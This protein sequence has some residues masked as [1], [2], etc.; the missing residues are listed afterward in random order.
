MSPGILVVNGT[1]TFAAGQTYIAEISAA[2]TPSPY[3]PIYNDAVWATG[4][5]SL[6]DINTPTAIQIQRYPALPSPDPSFGQ[7]FTILRAKYNTIP[8]PNY[9]DNFPDNY[10]TVSTTD[11]AGRYLLVT[12]ANTGTNDGFPHTSNEYAVYFVRGAAGYVFP[13]VSPTVTQWVQTNTLVGQGGPLENPGT[14]VYSGQ[15][16]IDPLAASLMVMND[17]DLY[18]ALLALTDEENKRIAVVDCVNPP[19]NATNFTAANN[20]VFNTLVKYAKTQPQY[21][22]NTGSNASQIV[23]SK[24]NISYFTT[25]NQQT[26]A[27]RTANN[28]IAGNQYPQFKTQTERLM[29]I[30]GMT[31]TA[32]RNKMTGQNPSGPAGVPCSTIYQIINS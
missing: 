15:Y 13:G 5:I 19:Y 10:F 23:A 22:L 32:A 24:Q 31:L 8:S 18:T 9:E 21:P 11:S 1:F 20:N 16:P 17:A 26:Q 25:M 12:P 7:R 3:G 30:Q 2:P 14:A 27:V 4:T 28:L 6:Q 29:Y